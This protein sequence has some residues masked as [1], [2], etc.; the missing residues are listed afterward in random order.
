MQEQR[1]KITEYFIWP[2]THASSGRWKSGIHL[3]G[4]LSFFVEWV[5]ACSFSVPDM[6]YTQLI[7]NKVTALPALFWVVWLYSD[8]VIIYC[9]ISFCEDIIQTWVYIKSF[10]IIVPGLNMLCFKAVWQVAR[11]SHISRTGIHIVGSC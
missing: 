1:F 6:H 4:K 9:D 5:P 7:Y 10:T 8:I 11:A 2:D 3:N